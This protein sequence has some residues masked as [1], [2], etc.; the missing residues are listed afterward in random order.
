[1]TTLDHYYDPYPT[2]SL[3][4]PL[5]LAGHPGS[6]VDRIGR[7]IAGRTG[8][9]F[10]DV[11][12]ASESRAGR[13]RARIVVEEGL[14]ALRALEEAALLQAVERTPFGVVVM[15]TGLLEDAAR[16]AWL[17]ARCAVV[18]VR[19]PDAALLERIRRQ[20][21]RSP[22]SLPEFLLGAP[23]RVEELKTYLAPREHA[24]RE[25]EIVLDAG[26]RHTT[27]IA[28]DILAS[29]NRLLGVERLPE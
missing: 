22:G 13:S 29:L 14:G 6:G 7:M 8:L 3:D 9:P 15:E 5:V 18:Y 17:Q 27:R 19:R 12:R 1:M 21:A 16:C 10:N 23:R 20:V 26:D 4:Q 24:L 25:I 11:E 2:L 28:S